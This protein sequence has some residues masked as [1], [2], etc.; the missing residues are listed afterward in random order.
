MGKRIFIPLMDPAAIEAN[1]NGWITAEQRK[2]ATPKL[3]EGIS[4]LDFGLF[5]YFLVFFLFP[6]LLA[7]LGHAQGLTLGNLPT[8][9]GAIDNVLFCGI[10]LVVVF[11][12][13]R[14][15]SSICWQIRERHELAEPTITTIEGKV[16]YNPSKARYQATVPGLKL[17]GIDGT[18]EVP[19]PPGVYRLH[20]LPVAHRVLSGE[21][22][23]PNEPGGP[24]TEIL[25]AL[26]QAHDFTAEDLALN[27]QGL[28]SPRQQEKLFGN[29]PDRAHGAHEVPLA[30]LEARVVRAGNSDDGDSCRYIWC[31]MRPLVIDV[32]QRAHYSLIPGLRY[33]VYYL[34]APLKL[35]S[36]EPTSAGSRFFGS[37]V[38]PAG[39]GKKIV[40]TDSID[41]ALLAE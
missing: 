38:R 40:S 41:P 12:G 30:T 27:Q 3:L 18:N 35:L 28:L 19:L 26:M 24:Y 7:F 36:L 29:E 32:P 1:Q 4:V 23:C 13:G 14:L 17:R 34:A 2:Q 20:Y 5:C 39:R 37:S 31:T 21:W 22:L 6:L 25:R 15:V 33:R 11:F 16:V 8:L 9:N 10:S